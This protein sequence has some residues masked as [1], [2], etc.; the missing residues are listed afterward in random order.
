MIAKTSAPTKA[1]IFLPSAL[2]GL[3]IK[4]KTIKDSDLNLK[5]KL[6]SNTVELWRFQTITMAEQSQMSLPR[7]GLMERDQTWDQTQFGQTIDTS[8][9]L[10]RKLMRPRRE[11]RGEA[12]LVASNPMLQFTT[13]PTTEPTKHLQLTSPSTLD[14]TIESIISK[15]KSN[16]IIVASYNY[17]HSICLQ[18]I[19]L[20]VW[21]YEAPFKI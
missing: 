21:I 20:V 15:P 3:W 13:R 17:S 19:Y 8:I 10:R 9:S 4:W 5:P 7:L 12:Q 2:P 11:W 16:Y 14:S 1:T 6:T 18:T